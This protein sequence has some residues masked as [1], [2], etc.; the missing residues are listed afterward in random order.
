MALSRKFLE[1]SLEL[2]E[3]RE[4]RAHKNHQHS[5]KE[6]RKDR[7]KFWIESEREAEKMVE[8]RRRQLAALGVA[9]PPMV[10]SGQLGL[11][12]QNLFGTK[13]APK[14]LAGHYDAGDRVKDM[15]ELKKTMRGH[16]AFHK[17]IGFGGLSYEALVADDGALGLGNPMWRKSA[18]VAG[19]NS[20]LVSICCPGTTGDKLTE[21]QMRT[22]L[23]YLRH[24]HTTAIPK[25]YRSPV[26]L[27]GL[28][29]KG[30]RE[31]PG[32]TTA[33]PG[34]QIPQWHEINRRK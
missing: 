5:A 7:E 31:F 10:T 6:G 8:K 2:W 12:F 23:W 4:R 28:T 1:E 34:D 9:R 25:P 33:C 19:N 20:N 26:K 15:D 21:A 3:A 18:A 27:T 11:T 16:H 17:S 30:H 22:A 13:G 14:H 32:Q 29:L 24:A